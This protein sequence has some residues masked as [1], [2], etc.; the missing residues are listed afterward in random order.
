MTTRPHPIAPPPYHAVVPHLVVA[1]ASDAIAFYKKAFGAIEKLRLADPERGGAI[2]SA[3][4]VIGDSVI[5]LA[6]EAPQWNARGPKALGGSP[7]VI[8]LNV[9]DPDAVAARAIKAGAKIIYPINDQL[10]GRREGRIE[11]PFGYQWKLSAVIEDVSVEEM[12]ARMA[13][14]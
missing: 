7:I 6:D 8:T 4:L 5:T 9:E 10:Y 1:G 14:V 12:Q 2:V 3:E 13:R 11:D